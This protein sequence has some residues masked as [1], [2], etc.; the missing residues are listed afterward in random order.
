M[1]KLA[2]ITTH[3][4]QYYAPLFKAVSE[5]GDVE[6]LVFYTW[7]EDGARIKFD[8][9]FKLAIEWDLPLLD[10]Y[11]YI[12]VENVAKDR[13]SHHFFGINN[14]KLNELIEN[15][16]PDVIWVW[17]W[18]FLSHLKILIYFKNK[19]P[20]WFRG[21]STLLDETTGLSFRKFIRRLFL[22]WVYSHV[23]K[24]FYVGENNK[25]YFLANRLKLN[26]LVKAPHAIDNDRFACL[27]ENQ[28][29]SLRDFRR[30]LG[31]G[32]NDFVV[33]FVG[34]L[35]P[36]KNPKF[37]IDCFQ[38]SRNMKMKFL[39]VGNGELEDEIKKLKSDR[40][41]FHDFVNQSMMPVIYRLGSILVL[42]SKGPGETWGL[43]LN[44]ALASGIP[45]AASNY[46]GGAIDL[47]DG[48]NGYI[49]KLEEGPGAILRD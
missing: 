21:D 7:G 18:A 39:F 42:P 27:T 19:V 46:C 37:L 13:G 22:G 3:P 23:D 20:I 11:R 15:F 28:K 29:N 31:I 8:P 38:L 32:L 5:L 30:I 48:E 16:K 36:K 44:E 43:A 6:L 1:K 24:A 4:I 45:V 47:I 35:E 25:N 34:K 2:I 9:D 49:F 33:L 26:Q 40:L 10:G 17:G 14:P 12:L 41:I